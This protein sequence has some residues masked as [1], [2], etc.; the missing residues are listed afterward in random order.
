MDSIRV[1]T[2]TA[3]S[4]EVVASHGKNSIL[5]GATEDGW[6]ILS[7]RGL[8]GVQKAVLVL[9]PSGK[10]SLD[11]FSDKAT[12]LSLGVV[13]STTGNGEEFS[14]HLKDK[15]NNVIWHPDVLNPY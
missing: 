6:A 11:L 15:R 8:D 2:L 5:L 9:T 1:N 12:R 4:V 7:F 3:G 10:P 13:D 14:L